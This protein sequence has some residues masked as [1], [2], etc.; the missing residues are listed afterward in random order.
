M[1]Q[2]KPELILNEYQ[3][4]PVMT[5][6][7]KPWVQRCFVCDKQVNFLKLSSEAYIRL[8]DVKRSDG[9]YDLV[10]HR[11]CYLGMPR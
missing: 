8:H 10:R 7:G 11:K 3:L 9:V 1:A 4:K 5:S 6:E 2:K